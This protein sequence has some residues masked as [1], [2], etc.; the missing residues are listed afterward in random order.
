M[1]VDANGNICIGTTSAYS[2]FC[3]TTTNGNFGITGGNTSG[4]NKIQSFGATVAS[5]GYLAFEG[6]D[7][8][9]MRIDSSGNLGVG[10]SSPRNVTNYKFISTDA[11]TGSGLSCYHNGTLGLSTYSVS[12]VSYISEARSAS[13]LFETSAT[14]RMRITSG[15]NVGIGI[16]TPG[17]DLQ[18][19]DTTTMGTGSATADIL[20]VTNNNGVISGVAGD[21][22]GIILSAMSDL[23]DRR[24]GLYSVSA[25]PNWNQPDFA[26]WQTG[27]GIAFR[28]TLRVTGGTS[29]ELKFNSGYGSVATAYG[30]RAWANFAGSNGAVSGSGNISSVSRTGTGLYQVNFSTAMPD[31]NYSV[32]TAVK[33]TSGQGST[34]GKVANIRFDNS[35]STSFFVIY[36][37]SN[38]GAE[39]FD[40]ILVSVFR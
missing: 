23:S 28:E 22:L 11:V 17:S 9:Y 12:G 15:G 26:V 33:P 37:Y 29:A 31:A 36:T 2:K 10:T 6:H 39:D 35:L 34:N 4:G 1:R 32:C 18:I 21:K 7:R 13:L 16:T 14:E 19:N 5:N 3:V 20:T 40:R 25:A 30:C 8:E 27:Q 38:A 24:V